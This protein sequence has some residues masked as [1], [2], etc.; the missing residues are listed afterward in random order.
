MLPE[1]NGSC[2]Y[3]EQAVA[4]SR[5]VVLHREGHVIYRYWF[6]NFLYN[7]SLEKPKK[8]TD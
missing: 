3:I 8:I 2:D 6:Q 4:G 5:Q 1:M 7:T